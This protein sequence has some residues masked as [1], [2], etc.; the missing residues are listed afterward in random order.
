MATKKKHYLEENLW[1]YLKAK[2]YVKGVRD[3][4][5]SAKQ[6]FHYV[7]KHFKPKTK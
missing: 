3:N 6:I 5:L 7:T 2:L 4:N 1:E